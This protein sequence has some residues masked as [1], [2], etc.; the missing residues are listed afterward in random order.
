M[1]KLKINLK[2]ALVVTVALAFMP[3]TAVGAVSTILVDPHQNI[4]KAGLT[5]LSVTGADLEPNTVIDVFQR[6]FAPYSALEGDTETTGV[7]VEQNFRGQHAVG[8]DGKISGFVPVTYDI[9]PPGVITPGGT[10]DY[11]D[12]IPSIQRLCVLSFVY[13]TGPL[14]GQSVLEQKLYFGMA[15]PIVTPPPV[16]VPMTKDDCKKDR[17]LDFITPGFKNQ[18]DCVSYVAGRPQ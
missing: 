16:T 10:I 13:S 9:I 8:A 7:K 18:G 12:T 17:W 1:K 3:W 6:S 2:N 11:C 4:P 5:Y 14:T 15:G